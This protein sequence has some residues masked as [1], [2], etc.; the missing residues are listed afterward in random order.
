M[1][2]QSKT[3]ELPDP[4]TYRDMPIDDVQVLY[5]NLCTIPYGE[6][7]NRSEID[8]HVKILRLRLEIEQA[9]TELKRYEA[10][11]EALSPPPLYM[12]DVGRR[13]RLVIGKYVGNLGTV[14]DPGSP[15]IRAL[16]VERNWRTVRFDGD[17]NQSI[18]D[19]DRLEFID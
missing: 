14:E 2:T 17:I 19:L 16:I 4:A 18:M 11:L 10:E 9:R 15:N 8:S 13:V 6:Y 7:A 1:N 5:S 12:R 3:I